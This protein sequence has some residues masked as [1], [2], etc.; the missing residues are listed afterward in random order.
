MDDFD[1]FAVFSFTGY[2]GAGYI[3]LNF[4][5][6][7]LTPLN[8]VN[9]LTMGINLNNYLQN[10]I[11]FKV[12][13]VEEKYIMLVYFSEY[14]LNFEM[15]KIDY[16]AG[17][18]RISLLNYYLTGLDELLT[19]FKKIN[20]KKLIFIC[21]NIIVE[22]FSL[23]SSNN[24]NI[25][26]ININKDNS[27]SLN[28]GVEQHILFSFGN[29]IPTWQIYGTYYNGYLLFS[30]NYKNRDDPVENNY[31]S[32]FMVLSYAN[33]TDSTTD[34]SLYLSDNDNY[35]ND[36]TFFEFLYQNLTIENNIFGYIA[37]NVIKLNSIPNEIIIMEENDLLPLENDSLMSQDNN[38][39]LQQNNNV[40][41]TPQYYHIDYQYLVK[42]PQDTN[43][44]PTY[45]YSRI[46]QLRFKLCHD[47]CD[48]CQELGSS[49]NDQKCLSCL[50]QYQYDYWY[51]NNYTSTNCVPE[52]YY[53][54]IETNTL[55]QCDHDDY[56]FYINTTDNKT[57]CFKDKYECPKSYPSFNSETKE[58][59]SCDYFRFKN[60]ECTLNNS[61]TTP[62]DI[63]EA[64]KEVLILN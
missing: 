44:E 32:L 13:Y 28:F 27:N 29:Y 22:D 38:Y 39:L 64:I 31:F 35:Q 4:Y 34:I 2:A 5:D 33:G 17:V 52:G 48:T 50:P 56:K 7:N 58:C 21:T 54:D 16:D 63:Y 26:I 14:F 15:Y 10:D 9:E 36:I 57:I 43:L 25:F 37:E 51:Y 47:Y 59:F 8:D 42:D 40:T 20:D 30:T 24:F 41:K 6:N 11:F 19:D 53:N 23:Q 18:E 62:E 46:N 1:T 61:Y 3:H 45:Y 55:L 60:G 12:V 49:N